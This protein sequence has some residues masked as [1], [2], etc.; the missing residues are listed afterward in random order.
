[1][2][3]D[4]VKSD[5]YMPGIWNVRYV[6]ANNKAIALVFSRQS[7]FIQLTYWISFST[8]HAFRRPAQQVYHQKLYT[9]RCAMGV[10][11]HPSMIRICKCWWSFGDISTVTSMALD[12]NK[13][14]MYCDNKCA[15]ALC[16]T[17]T[18]NI[19]RS[20]AYRTSDFTSS[21]SML[22]N[23]SLSRVNKQDFR[24]SESYQQ[25][26]YAI[27]SGKIPP[28]TK[29][30]KKKADSDATTKQKPPTVPK[31]K[32]GKKTGKGKQKAKDGLVQ[33]KV[34]GVSLGVPDL[35]LIMTQNDDISWKLSEDDQDED[36][37][38]D[39]ENVQDDDDDVKSGDDELKSQDDQ[40]DDDEAQTESEDDVHTPSHVS[41]SDDKDSDN[42]VEGWMLEETISDNDATMSD[43]Q[44]Q[45]YKALVDAYEDDKILLDTYGDTVTI[46][47]P[48]DG[49]DDD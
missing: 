7:K 22:E 37:N 16:C 18:F 39:D 34:T 40:D 11:Y 20:K 31:E 33:M 27:A 14:P 29:A 26:Y 2:L 8:F 9:T 43:I 44:R 13:I 3:L 15:I 46:K 49:A 25:R 1:M 47:K 5:V 38:E 6:V 41:S 19:S 10:S 30:S 21:R 45:L 48:R 24:N 42:E 35:H 36:K 23:G 32:K 4:E 12:F 28:K 17:T